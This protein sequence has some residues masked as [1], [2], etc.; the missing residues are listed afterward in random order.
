MIHYHGLPMGANGDEVVRFL[1]GRHAFISFASPNQIGIASE[2][3]Q[4]FAID[5]G[6]F[7]AWKS[8]QGFDFSGYEDF[9]LEWSTHPSCDWFIIPDVI[10]G[11][12]ED[13]QEL[14]SEWTSSP[15]LHHLRRQMV[16]VF[17]LHETIGHLS[18]L[19]VRFD[20]IC[21]G[22]SGE[23]SDPG[24]RAWWGRIA[25]LMKLI[26]DE[27]GRPRCKIHGLRM[28]DPDIFTRIP[29]SS[30]DST[31][32]ARNCGNES[33]WSR[34]YDPIKKWVRA[35]VIAERVEMHQSSAAWTKQEE[36]L[37]KTRSLFDC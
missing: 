16:P 25:E 24:S 21:L 9:V 26:C 34:A 20:R 31:N 8:G 35:T 3:C 15:K 19:L 18:N 30:A 2:V 10:D 36:G 4:S 5:N 29:L 33:A 23:F 13:N 14:I 22:S 28:L 1:S 17:H 11:T 37:W 32:A 12:I 7:S 6:A 27:K